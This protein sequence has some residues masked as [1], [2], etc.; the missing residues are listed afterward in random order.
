MILETQYIG[1]GS[2]PVISIYRLLNM[3]YG[4]S[5]PTK[6]VIVVDREKKTRD[7]VHLAC[8]Y[9]PS[10][11]TVAISTTGTM[12]QGNT[13]GWHK[14]IM[15]YAGLEIINKPNDF[16]PFTLSYMMYYIS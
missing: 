8:L 12:T 9:S 3:P 16:T 11:N 7:Y 14:D 2:D 4:P 13:N 15:F 1:S 6:M 5:I 10:G